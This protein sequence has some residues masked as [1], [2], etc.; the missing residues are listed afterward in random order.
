MTHSHACH[1]LL[2]CVWPDLVICETRLIHTR[3]MPYSYAGLDSLMCVCG[4]V[5]AYMWQDSF[6][7]MTWLIHMCDVIRIPSNVLH[8]LRDTCSVLQC[9]AV[10]CS[11]LQCAAVCCSVL[12][13]AAVCWSVLQC[14]AVCCSVLKCVAVWHDPPSSALHYLRDMMLAVGAKVLV[15]AI[16]LAHTLKMS[17]RCSI[18]YVIRPQRAL[19]RILKKSARCSMYYV[20]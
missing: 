9:V 18:Y 11:V 7:C 10:C 20:K 17:A 3:H 8:N 4:I 6:I 12:Q 19:L 5:H 2:I 1:D 16:H 15:Q 14:V 13:C